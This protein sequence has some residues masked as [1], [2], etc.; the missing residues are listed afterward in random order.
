VTAERAWSA[1]RAM[2]ELR[3]R[4][5][6]YVTLLF[7]AAR[8]APP[9]RA[10]TFAHTAPALPAGAVAAAAAVTAA[11]APSAPASEDGA[12]AR[13]RYS[14]SLR[15]EFAPTPHAT[16]LHGFAGYFSAEL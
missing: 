2:G 16:L 1:A 5:T 14:R 8:L 6:P 15:L 4:E 12:A 9:R 7:R 11:E 13:A 10:F 3:W